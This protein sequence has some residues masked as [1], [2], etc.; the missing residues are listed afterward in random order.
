MQKRQGKKGKRTKR[1]IVLLPDHYGYVAP[2]TIAMTCDE[3]LESPSQPRHHLFVLQ[4]GSS[5]L[6]PRIG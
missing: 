5:R 1:G 2:T 3:T 6:P 4:Y